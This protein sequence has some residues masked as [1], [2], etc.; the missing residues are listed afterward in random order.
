MSR[1]ASLIACVVVAGS[2]NAAAQS[3]ELAAQ[4][5]ALDQV[6]LLDGPFKRAM[7]T[8]KQVLLKLDVD[9][10][11][12]AYH[13]HAGLPTKG[14]RY[15]GWARKDCVGQISGHYMSALSMMHASSGESEYKRRLDYM[16]SE[17]ARIQKHYGN[18]YTGPVRPEVWKNTFDGSIEVHAWGLGG[19]Y[20]PWY[21]MHKTYAGLLDAY[22]LTG[23]EQALKVV[24]GLADWAKTQTDTLD[25]EQFQKMLLAEHGGMAESLADLHAITGNQDYL[26]LAKR[27]EHKQITDPLAQERDELTGKHVN[28]QLPKI[29]AAARLYELTGDQRHAT[30]A[31]FLW[32]Q[33]VN[34]RAFATGGV[35]L[36]E[37]YFEPGK[38]AACLEW[39]SS[40]TCA[41]YNMLKLTRHLFSWEPDAQLMDYYE[42]GLY[43]QILGSQDPVGGGFTYFYSLRPGHFKTYSN[44]FDAMWCC[45]GTGIENHSKYGDTIYSHDEDTLWVNL[46]IPSEVKWKQR[47]VTVRQETSFPDADTMS[48]SLSMKREQSFE[49]RIRVPYWATKGASIWINGHE[50][51]V[52]AKPQSYLKLSRNWKDGDTVKL[53]LPMSLHLHRARDNADM[54][55]VMYGPL[56]LAGEL[57]TE[58]MPKDDVHG[59]QS[60]HAG[61][62]A[63]P[64]P[65]LLLGDKQLDSCVKRVPGDTLRFKTIGIGRPKDVTLV[66]LHA[67]HH[68][69]YAVYWDTKAGKAAISLKPEAIAESKLVQGLEYKYYQSAWNELPDFDSLPILKEGVVDNFDISKSDQRDNFAFLFSGYLKIPADGEYYFSTGSDDGSALY[70]AGQEL[71]MNDGIHAVIN[72]RSGPVTLKAGFYP[73]EV[74][75]FEASGG[76]ALQVQMYDGSGSWQ[77][78]PRE[79][80]YRRK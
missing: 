34:K 23:N 25:E 21:V 12:W 3:V 55:V 74:K 44:P 13:E 10:M 14:E 62:L 43:N 67:L 28:T 78:I 5:F 49:I 66:P 22:T 53:Q 73:L 61:K 63:P 20:V 45:V 50:V 75:F 31:K 68:Q 48:F 7:E 70:L 4:P 15:G 52:N 69:R 76:E 26:D 19:G 27:F 29:L 54:A 38:E 42:R 16:V 17:L 59:S 65:R 35:D 41:V 72:V 32:D 71:V 60:A 39:N 24:R 47:G 18:G 64:V 1:L 30:I 36:R 57:G 51:K 40:E 9:R 11:L 37:H 6:R 2:V 33:T 77:R 80:I 8:N 58:G 79:M 56:T 46:F